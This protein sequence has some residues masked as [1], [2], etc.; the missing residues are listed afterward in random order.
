[1]KSGHP[2][3]VMKY[4]VVKYAK[5]LCEAPSKCTLLLKYVCSMLS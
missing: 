4:V 2:Y 5:S 3:V 1:M